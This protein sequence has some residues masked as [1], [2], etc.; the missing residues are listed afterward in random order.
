MFDQTNREVN[1]T[2]QYI[3]KEKSEVNLKVLMLGIGNAQIDVIFRCK[4]SG[5]EMVGISYKRKGNGLE[6]VDHFVILIFLYSVG[7]DIAMPTIGYV[8]EK[9]NM[10]FFIDA[11]TSSLLQDKGAPKDFLT[12]HHIATPCWEIIDSKDELKYFTHYPAVIKPVD[13]QGQRAIYKV[14][15]LLEAEN[16]YKNSLFFSKKKKVIIEE[17]IDGTE[18]SENAFVW[19]GEVIYHFISERYVLEG[20]PD[21]IPKGHACQP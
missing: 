14:D 13:S 16:Y 9:L 15:N 3:I 19:N 12:K 1:H 20:Y 11:A 2:P 5:Y 8:F 21:G 7:L 17:C 10:P 18:I 4:E 6:L